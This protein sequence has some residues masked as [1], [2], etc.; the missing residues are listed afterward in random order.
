MILLSWK[1]V[2]CS[3]E[4][5]TMPSR[6]STK[7]P[8]WLSDLRIADGVVILKLFP[9]PVVPLKSLLFLL[10][11]YLEHVQQFSFNANNRN[12]NLTRHKVQSAWNDRK[13]WIRAHLLEMKAL[14]FVGGRKRQGRLE[15]FLKAVA[16]IT[17]NDKNKIV[18]NVLHYRF[19]V[20]SVI[21]LLD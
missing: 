19:G 7:W 15:K 13:V 11:C 1:Y 8:C 21:F 10:P 14:G 18:F 16:C 12:Y 9:N 3:N 2:D 4:S 5:C 20:V 17:V 6:L